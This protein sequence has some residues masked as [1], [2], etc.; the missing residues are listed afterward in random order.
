MREFES[1]S[2]HKNHHDMIKFPSRD[3]PDYLRVL[4]YLQSM[5]RDPTHEPILEPISLETHDI[6][7]GPLSENSVKALCLGNGPI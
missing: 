7:L 5:K 6:P 2:L 1:V 4:T 3:D